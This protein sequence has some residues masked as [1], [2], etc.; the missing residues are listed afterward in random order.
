MMGDFFSQR[1]FINWQIKYQN[2]DESVLCQKKFYVRRRKGGYEQGNKKVEIQKY[3]PTWELK[4]P[5]VNK[6]KGKCN[7]C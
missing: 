2:Q 4:G 1:K 5:G 7:G 6:L 3:R